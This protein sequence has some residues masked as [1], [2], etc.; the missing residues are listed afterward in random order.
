MIIDP[1]FGWGAPVVAENKVQVEAIVGLWEAG[2]SLETVADEYGLTRE[3]VEA[4]CRTT[5]RRAA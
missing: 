5:H 1:R 3:Q 4:I 2:E